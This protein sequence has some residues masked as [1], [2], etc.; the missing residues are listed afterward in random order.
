MIKRIQPSLLMSWDRN[1]VEL[2]SDDDSR[3]RYVT[4]RCAVPQGTI[5]LRDEEPT[6]CFRSASTSESDI[7]DAIIAST[8]A[9]HLCSPD[10]SALALRTQLR[11]HQKKALQQFYA[12]AFVHVDVNAASGSVEYVVLYW[13]I[14]MMNHSCS[15]N[16]FL[17]TTF[18]QAP[19]Q[20]NEGCVGIRTSV[21][22]SR[23]LKEGEEI[24]IAYQLLLAPA[25]VR[26]AF[27]ESH[28]GFTCCCR[29]CADPSADP[30]EQQLLVQDNAETS[31][32]AFRRLEKLFEYAL[33]P[34]GRRT[35]LLLPPP[36]RDVMWQ[37][38]K[39][40]STLQRG[41][42]WNI[43]DTIAITYYWKAACLRGAIIEQW[44]AGCAAA[45]MPQADPVS[46]LAIITTQHHD[47]SQWF[48][49]GWLSHYHI[50]RVVP[51]T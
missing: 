42:A 6:L 8:L 49:N 28:Y 27:F 37:M 16:V 7:C 22:V 4:A 24:C 38:L 40:V 20:G 48:F 30:Q 10:T 5:L 23:E 51:Q 33:D 3:G 9:E 36:Q 45:V 41:T 11:P 12:N 15:P 46:I 32:A 26:K 44:D 34:T 25:D 18:H 13:H 39:T 50:Q 43:L 47:F 35:T 29:R 17:E 21:V 2:H 1:L 19:D 31:S 14:S